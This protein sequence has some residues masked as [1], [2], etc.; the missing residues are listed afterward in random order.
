MNLHAN[1]ALSLKGRR[2]LCRGVVERERTLAQ[3]AGFFTPA[4]GRGRLAAIMRP[5]H[6]VVGGASG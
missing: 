5:A 4:A 1:A 3:A 2:E 6:W